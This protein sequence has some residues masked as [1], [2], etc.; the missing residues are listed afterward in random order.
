MSRQNHCYLK[1]F[2]ILLFKKEKKNSTCH[3]ESSIF[4]K[5]VSSRERR[6]ETIKDRKRSEKRGITTGFGELNKK[7]R[8][9]Q[10]LTSYLAHL[11]VM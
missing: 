9:T 3:L 10:I 7:R 1:V 5:Y 4:L 11:S 6:I 8:P 2:A